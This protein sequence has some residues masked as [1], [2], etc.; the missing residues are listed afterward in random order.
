M[1]ERF[2]GALRDWVESRPWAVDGALAMV[3]AL[4]SLP[5]LWQLDEATLATGF[6]GPTPLTVGIALAMTLPLAWC[7]RAPLI[8]TLVIAGGYLGAAALVVPTLPPRRL[9]RPWADRHGRTS[10]A[11]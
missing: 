8:A 5:P 9:G 2:G 7:R 1:T 11:G 6:D 10:P 3:V 4:V